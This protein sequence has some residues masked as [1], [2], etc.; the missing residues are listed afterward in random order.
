MSFDSATRHIDSKRGRGIEIVASTL[1]AHPRSAVSRAP[2][3]Q[4]GVGIVVGR[5]P[6]RAAAGLPLIA[7]RPG[8]A[9]GFAGGRNGVGPPE[10]LAGLEV[11]R[12]DEPAN[13]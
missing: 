8:F 5:D 10:F 1:V 2:E 11:E 7:L 13:A 9:A 6:Y 12:G 3:R 4:I